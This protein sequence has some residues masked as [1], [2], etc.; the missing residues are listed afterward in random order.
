[1]A[2][3]KARTSIARIP[4]D[5]QVHRPLANQVAEWHGVATFLSVKGSN[6]ENTPQDPGHKWFPAPILSPSTAPAL[7]GEIGH[8][9]ALS[10]AGKTAIIHSEGGNEDE[11]EEILAQ[12]GEYEELLC[13]GHD[14]C[15]HTDAIELPSASLFSPV[16][17]PPVLS[18]SAQDASAIKVRD[19]VV[20]CVLFDLEMQWVVSC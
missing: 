2:P 11:A 14:E 12:H 13:M 6:P 20:P 3:E 16:Q 4:R 18:I 15:G 8:P 5:H 10:I 19:L 1:M 7:A 9:N 17:A